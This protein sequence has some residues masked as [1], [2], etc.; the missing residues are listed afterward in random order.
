MAVSVDSKFFVTGH[1]RSEMIFI[2]IFSK[3]HQECN[4]KLVIIPNVSFFITILHS[5]PPPL[6]S[7]C[8][9]SEYLEG[10]CWERVG[11]LFQVR[12]SFYI[13]NKLKFEIFNG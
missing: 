8:E 2:S 6:F 1:S 9:G 5:V 13:K 12:C 4:G 7:C 11:G 3:H 10:G